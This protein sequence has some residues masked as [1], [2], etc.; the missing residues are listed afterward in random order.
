MSHQGKRRIILVG[1][2][3][4]SKNLHVNDR[5]L[6]KMLHY[7]NNRSFPSLFGHKVMLTA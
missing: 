3:Q 6:L 2:I 1:V 7:H 4:K 5:Q